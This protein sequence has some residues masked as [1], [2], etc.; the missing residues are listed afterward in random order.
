MKKYFKKIY[1]F[2]S[3]SDSPKC[4]WKVREKALS[5]SGII[6]YFYKYRWRR[7]TQRYH[8]FIPL[9]STF[10]EMPSFPHD[11]Y[12]IFISGGAKIGAN[13]TIFHQVTIGSNTLSDSKKRGAP[14][15]GDNVYIGAGAKIIGGIRIGNNVR[16]GANC[17]VT[18]DVAD[19]CTVVLTSPR[20]ITHNTVRD[21]SFK[22][23]KE[24]SV[25]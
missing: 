3:Q 12:G 15:I 19:N 7:I 21:N 20:I 9:S 5:S 10:S 25:E 1:N 6:R 16:I 17:V 8:A 24:S 14:I 23:W 13:C 18:H 22:A 2:V 11:F 4:R